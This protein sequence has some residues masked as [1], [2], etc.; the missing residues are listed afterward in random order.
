LWGAVFKKFEFYTAKIIKICNNSKNISKRP[1]CQNLCAKKVL[2]QK[3]FK[4]K[5]FFKKH[6]RTLD[7]TPFFTAFGAQNGLKMPLK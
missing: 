2:L 3:K 4:K 7:D 5:E 6:L 1:W